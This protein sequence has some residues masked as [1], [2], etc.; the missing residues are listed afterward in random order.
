VVLVAVSAVGSVV[1]SAEQLV[2]GWAHV[3]VGL[4]ASA[5][6][7][8]SAAELARGWGPE[9][10]QRWGMTSAA[11]RG[12]ELEPKQARSWVVNWAVAKARAMVRG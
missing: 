8:Q 12:E 4:R 9:L 2:R 7:A 6:A 1:K 11:V 10:A 3:W 5:W